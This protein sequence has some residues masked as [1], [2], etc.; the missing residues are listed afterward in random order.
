MNLKGKIGP[1]HTLWALPHETRVESVQTRVGAILAQPRPT[2]LPCRDGD[3]EAAGAP[4][5]DAPATAP[6]LPIILDA[7]AGSG[8]CCQCPRPGA[9]LPRSCPDLDSCPEL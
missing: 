1:V 9:G 3:G 4:G 7:C 8:W 2:A 6:Q 5:G